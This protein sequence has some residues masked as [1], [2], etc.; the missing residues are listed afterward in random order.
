MGDQKGKSKRKG[1]VEGAMPSKAVMQVG[2]GS[3]ADWGLEVQAS[4]EGHD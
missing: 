3:G 2:E 4:K 1:E